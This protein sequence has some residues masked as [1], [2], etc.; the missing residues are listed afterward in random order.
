MLL[1]LLG[2][3]GRAAHAH[4]ICHCGLARRRHGVLVGNDQWLVFR[5]ILQQLPQGFARIKAGGHVLRAWPKA[6]PPVE[7][8]QLLGAIHAFWDA[9]PEPGFNI[10]AQNSYSK[11][12][13]LAQPRQVT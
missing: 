2:R 3:E 4:G 8:L 12:T 11:A 7:V 9:N 1:A 13:H 5:R 10:D 6:R